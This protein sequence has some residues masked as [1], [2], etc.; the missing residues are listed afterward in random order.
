MMDAERLGL[1]HDFAFSVHGEAELDVPSRMVIFLFVQNYEL[2]NEEFGYCFDFP[3]VGLCQPNFFTM[4]DVL[5]LV[6][7]RREK[8]PIKDRK[9]NFL[10]CSEDEKVFLESF[11]RWASEIQEWVFAGC[12]GRKSVDFFKAG[13]P[14]LAC[15]ALPS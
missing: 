5:Q 7:Q 15:Y 3:G 1:D 6:W 4:A 2:T 9:M 14:F 12:R 8:L 11:L 10:A 13:T